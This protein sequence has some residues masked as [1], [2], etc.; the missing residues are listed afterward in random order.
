[1]R[2]KELKKNSRNGK[3][4]LTAAKACL[5][6]EASAR[7]GVT[8]LQLGDL[9]VEFTQKREEPMRTPSPWSADA[10]STAA[11]VVPLQEA[12][13]NR[14]TEMDELRLREEQIEELLLTDPLAAEEMIR[15]G[16]LAEETDEPND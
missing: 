7:A 1:M 14:S 16:D 2:T 10:I 6:I 12:E 15:T 5:I 9:Y 11:M 13:E 4:S 3:A 8:L